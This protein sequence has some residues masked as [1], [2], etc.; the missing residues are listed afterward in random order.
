MPYERAVTQGTHLV[1][2]PLER[3]LLVLPLH[4]LA[5]LLVRQLVHVHLEER[6][7]AVNTWAS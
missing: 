3:E 5:L 4:P 2:V 6:L 7:T 1:R